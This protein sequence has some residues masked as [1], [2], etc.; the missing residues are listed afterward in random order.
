MVQRIFH[1]FL[2]GETWGICSCAYLSNNRGGS[3][4]GKP[5]GG[6]WERPAQRSGSRS[7]HCDVGAP[8]ENQTSVNGVRGSPRLEPTLHWWIRSTRK[9][10]YGCGNI[11]SRYLSSRVSLKILKGAWFYKRNKQ[12]ICVDRYRCSHCPFL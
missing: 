4:P 2:K 11:P 7:G 10:G 12:K 5:S 6:V 8:G 3:F 9:G 1:G